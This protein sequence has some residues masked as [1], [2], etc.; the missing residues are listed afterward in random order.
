MG[1]KRVVDSM[2]LL[3]LRAIRRRLTRSAHSFSAYVC[4]AIH[5]GGG[6]GGFASRCRYTAITDTVVPEILL[7]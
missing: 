6:G 4:V 3:L 1:S 5:R 7:R 2:I